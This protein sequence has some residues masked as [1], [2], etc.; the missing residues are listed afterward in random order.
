MFISKQYNERQPLRIVTFGKTLVALYFNEKLTQNNYVMS[1]VKRL[2][3]HFVI[4]HL[5][6]ILEYDLKNKRNTV[7]A[8]VLS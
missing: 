5:L 8:K 4:D 7:S 3:L 2:H 1:R 6:L